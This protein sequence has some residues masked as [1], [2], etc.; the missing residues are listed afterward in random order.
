MNDTHPTC[1]QPGKGQVSMSIEKQTARPGDSNW[2]PI[3]VNET[4]RLE[5]VR[6]TQLLD[7]PTESP[8]DA[9]TQLAAQIFDVPIALV[10]LVESN[11]QFLKS[12]FGLDVTETPR[13]VS[14]CT[15]AIVEPEKTL[16]VPDATLDERFHDNPLVTGFPH[17]RAYVGAPLIDYQ[18]HALGSLCIIDT[19]PRD[20][21]PCQIEALGTLSRQVGQLIEL[22][23]INRQLQAESNARENSDQSRLTSELRLT[24]LLSNIK[25]H[26][27]LMLDEN[28]IIQSWNPGV[29]MIFGYEAQEILGKSFAMLFTDEDRKIGYPDLELENARRNGETTGTGQRIRKD[30]TIIWVNYS[31]RSITDESGRCIGFS[32]VSSDVSNRVADD[33]RFE[34]KRNRLQALTDCS[35]SAIVEL[36]KEGEIIRANQSAAEILG[37][38]QMQG[39]MYN[40]PCWLHETLDGDPIPN[41]QMPFSIVRHTNQT[42]RDHVVAIRKPDGSRVVLSIGGAPVRGADG[43]TVS[44]IFNAID[45]TQQTNSLHALKI[46]EERYAMA[47]SATEDALWDWH[48]PSGR[49]TTSERWHT[50]LGY[51]GESETSLMMFEDLIHVDDRDSLVSAISGHFSGESA[52]FQIE[53]RLRRAD[54]SYAYVRSRGKVSVRD[55]EGNPIRMVGTHQDISVECEALNQLQRAKEQ[56][57]EMLDE[58]ASSR[59]HLQLAVD[60]TGSGLWDWNMGTGEITIN[61]KWTALLGYKRD[62]LPISIES[63]KRLT[64][65]QDVKRVLNDLNEHDR[66]STSHFESEFRMKHAEGYDVWICARGRIM[67]RDESGRAVRMAGTS[68]DVTQ[69]KSIDA[70]LDAARDAANAANAA[71][72]E[73]LANMSHELRT[74][75]TAILGFSDLLGEEDCSLENRLEYVNTI[76]RNAEHLL[77]VINDIL[78]LSKIEAGKLQCES[79][80][81]NPLCKVTDIV[82]LLRVRAVSKGISLS[83]KQES[84][85]PFVIKS[86]PTRLRQILIN[87]VGNA[88]KFTEVGGV[89]VRLNFDPIDAKLRIDVID[90]GIG[91]TEEQRQRIFSPFVQADT[92]TSRRF[93]GTGLGLAISVRLARLL[94]GE[95]KVES[96]PQN[97]SMF[98]LILPVSPDT[99][100]FVEPDVKISLESR[101]NQITQETKF[102][103]GIKGMRILLVEDGPDNQKLIAFH[104]KREGA[105]YEIADN[106]QLGIDAIQNAI[107][108]GKPFDAVLMDMQMPVL[109][110]YSATREIRRQGIITPVIAL[111]AHAMSGDREKCLA[112]GCDDYMTK[113]IQ[114]GQMSQ[115]ILGACNSRVVTA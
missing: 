61:E 39:T 111:T 11:R 36:S 12:R 102:A 42:I 28:G 96:T 9:L 82:D 109:D 86:D 17:I 15:H 88:V 55:D 3:P 72:S 23:R 43:V 110:G 80:D 115:V 6:A 22:K 16:V 1:S 89:S 78:D 50:M 7:T 59:E 51:P 57:I 31:V 34:E 84:P 87:L 91:L 100:T 81:T 18:G 103:Q 101:S 58:I 85:L 79:I 74:P 60:G 44:F 112:A 40:A 113:P 63:W 64:H 106:G 45:I 24:T 114:P 35:T 83:I 75:M 66:Q 107:A 14:F 76:R 5:A 104:L 67:V 93:G 46:S 30:G 53:L 108:Q 47:L 4:Q 105:H 70:K 98:S 99:A 21:T 29:R 27:V 37:I 92:S 19:R 52:T 13:C 41:E 94:G 32:K 69:R 65:P 38:V 2:Y 56:A 73:F 97:G 90:T 33:R 20:F 48:V 8:F 62:D 68:Q 95:I 54:G 10:S 71:K 26:L 25:D 77:S 49:V